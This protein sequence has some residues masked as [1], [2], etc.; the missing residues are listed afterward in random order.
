MLSRLPMP[1]NLSAS[2][3]GLRLS[4]SILVSS[5]IPYTFALE[6]LSLHS[7]RK[8]RHYLDTFLFQV[9]RGLKTCTSL[10]KNVSLRVTV[11]NVR[12][13]LKSVFVPIVN[14]VL[15]GEPMVS[16]WRVKISTYLHTE[17]FLSFILWQVD[18]M[19][20][21]DLETNNYTTAVAK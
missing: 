16:K 8:R 10:V 13:F 1:A 5:H 11:R 6:K 3:R 21:N 9:Y 4:V 12:D 19:L 17:R 18:P 2:S 14:T 7:L 20:C 15:L